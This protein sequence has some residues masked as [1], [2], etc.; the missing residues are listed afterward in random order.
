MQ[1]NISNAKHTLYICIAHASLL[2][3]WRRQNNIAA[4]LPFIKTTEVYGLPYVLP[5]PL[6]SI[7]RRV[8]V[9]IWI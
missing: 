8:L 2:L 1:S 3:T 7:F 9:L 5:L 4:L 6:L